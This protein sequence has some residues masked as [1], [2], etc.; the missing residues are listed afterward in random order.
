[1]LTKMQKS[2]LN[3]T[4]AQMFVFSR[5]CIFF[6]YCISQASEGVPIFKKKKNIFVT[7]NQLKKMALYVPVISLPQG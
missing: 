2:L 3:L 7:I 5:E 1:M 4:Y 6:V